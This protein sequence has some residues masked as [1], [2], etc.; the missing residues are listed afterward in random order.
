M[1]FLK[2]TFKSIVTIRPCSLRVCSKNIKE[3]LTFDS[4]TFL[5][6][7]PNEQLQFCFVAT[8]ISSQKTSFKKSPYHLTYNLP[9]GIPTKS[10]L[11]QFPF[12]TVAC[13]IPTK[14]S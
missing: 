7:H 14:T 11:K 5:H 9:F 4:E 8:E 10:P 12:E 3:Q 13:A 6:K 1:G 2:K